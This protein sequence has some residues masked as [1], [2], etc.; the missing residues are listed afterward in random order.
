MCPK[1]LASKE[2]NMIIFMMHYL[3]EEN[4]SDVILFTWFSLRSKYLV[5]E[6]WYFIVK[7]LRINFKKASYMFYN[8]FNTEIRGEV[9]VDFLS[10]RFVNAVIL[11]NSF[12]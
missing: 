6:T 1:L 11:T 5:K 12:N 2:V 9:F 10:F 3:Y 8:N 7:Y 4:S